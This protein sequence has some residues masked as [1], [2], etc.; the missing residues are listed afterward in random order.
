[1]ARRKQKDEESKAEVGMERWLISYAGFITL[2][3]IFFVIIHAGSTVDLEKYDAMAYSFSLVLS[4]QEKD[5][6]SSMEDGL[7]GQVLP[8]GGGSP[9][10]NQGQLDEV[11]QLIEEFIEADDMAIREVQK[12]GNSSVAKLSEN[13]VIY[14]QERGLVISFKDKMLFSGESAALTPRA[15][16]IISN[17]GSVLVRQ[18]NFIRVEGH[19]DDRLVKSDKFRSNWD[20]SV[21]RASNVVHVLD[22]QSKVPAERLSIIG[23]G[24][25]RPLVS[26]D[27]EANRAMNRRVDIV[28]LKKKYDYF[29]PPRDSME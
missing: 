29:E 2:L 17:I 21:L 14:E 5:N 16:E 24:E 26:N 13:L 3:M 19:T 4:G 15:R 10:A 8:V 12:S 20:L 22:E 27:S 9:A 11:K 28:I 7:S 1:M 6:G 25:H 18:P 23:Y